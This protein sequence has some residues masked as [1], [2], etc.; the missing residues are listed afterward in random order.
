[1]IVNHVLYQDS[2]LYY[3]L[4]LKK[5]CQYVTIVSSFC[6]SVVDIKTS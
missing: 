5:L 2:V 3:N 6:K 1:M 4:C